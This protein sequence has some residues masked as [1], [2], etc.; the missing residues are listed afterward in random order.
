VPPK[1]PP[2]ETSVYWPG[3]ETPKAV[4]K[5]EECATSTPAGLEDWRRRSK[6]KA[7]LT[8]RRRLAGLSD[9]SRRRGK[10]EGE[11]GPREPERRRA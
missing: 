1:I 6:E 3:S 10:Q 2:V 9:L 7:S 4:E 11:E 5:E 8:R